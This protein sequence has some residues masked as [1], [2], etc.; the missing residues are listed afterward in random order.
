MAATAAAAGARTC[1][2][3]CSTRPLDVILERPRA[4]GLAQHE[5]KFLAQGDSW[6]SFGSVNPLLTGSILEP[7]QFATDRCAVDC[8][9]PG[10]TLVHMIEQ[11]RNPE[12]LNLLIGAQNWAWDALLRSPGGNDLIDFIRTPRVDQRGNPVP[13]ALRALFARD[14]RGGRTAA[15]ACISEDGW[16]TFVAHIVAQF[17]E[18]VALRDCASSKSQGVPIFAHS[19]DLITPRNAG[20][21]LGVGPWLYPALI[22]YEVPDRLWVEL[23]RLFLDRL[24][25]LMQA[26]NLPNFHLVDTQGTLSAAAPGSGGDSDDWAD[27]IHP[28]RGGYGKL[29]KVFA[30]GIAALLP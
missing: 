18:F 27:E 21:G 9:H 4:Q 25:A 16:A 23:T 2:L 8:A 13:V 30:A 24:K 14:E 6:F 5:R 17:H 26:L 10:D 29:A 20:A 1:C 22:A 7:M 15:A 11:R 28:N 3:S 12:F 19:D